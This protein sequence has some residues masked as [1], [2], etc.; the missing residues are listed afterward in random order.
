M[1]VVVLMS[2]MKSHCEYDRVNC[3]DLFDFETSEAVKWLWEN[4]KLNL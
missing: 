1:L 3:L 2:L 4:A